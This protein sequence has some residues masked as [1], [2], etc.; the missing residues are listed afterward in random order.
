MKHTKYLN[1]ILFSAAV[2]FASCGANETKDADS[3]KVANE[4]NDEKIETNKVEKDAEALVSLSSQ[5]LYLAEAGKY[6]LA[7]ANQQKVKDLAQK[8]SS[9][10]SKVASE[11][12]DFAAKRNYNVPD[13]MGND[14]VKDAEDMK[15]WKKGKEF[16][17]K[18]VD[19]V[20]DEHEKAIRIL[21]DR[22]NNTADA[23]LKAWC[24]KTLAAM[25][26][27]L[28]ESKRVKEEI[29]SLYKS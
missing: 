7:N 22:A 12:K 26:T 23:D 18:F 28:D 29:S 2:F 24:E 9:D 1:G 25:R 21:E 6:A 10:H 5:D 4:A 19:E 14:Y 11:V 16:D 8:I 17:T 20:I 13:V 27:H 3:E 15:N